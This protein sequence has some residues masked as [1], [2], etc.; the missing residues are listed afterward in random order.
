[1]TPPTTLPPVPPDL[2][3]GPGVGLGVCTTSEAARL[4]GVSATT[5]QVMVERGELQAWKTRGGHRRIDRASI[6]AVRAARAGVAGAA[7]AAAPVVLMVVEE[8]AASRARIAA[9]VAG[10]PVPVRLRWADDA[11]DALVGIERHRPDVLLTGLRATPIDGLEFVRRLRTVPEYRTMAVVVVTALGED[12]IQARGGL[13]PGIVRYGEPLPLD[14][15]GGF[16]EACAL[17]KRLATG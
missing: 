1:M 13:P 12:A 2:P 11:F 4:L 10:W 5:V 14:R 8:G 16:V 17:G 9:A 6:D 3:I 7:D 15:L